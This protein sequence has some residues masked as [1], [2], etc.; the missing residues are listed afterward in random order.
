[1]AV[2]IFGINGEKL[3]SNDLAAV[4]EKKRKS[5]IRYNKAAEAQ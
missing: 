3:G 1:L 4:L 2:C 5:Q